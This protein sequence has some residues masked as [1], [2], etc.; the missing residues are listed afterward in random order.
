MGQVKNLTDLLRNPVDRVLDA[1]VGDDGNNGCVDDSEVVD[2]KD[3]ELGV[4]DARLDRPLPSRAV[5]QGSIKS[6]ISIIPVEKM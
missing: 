2:P 5:P 3:L 6:S 1:A 4:D